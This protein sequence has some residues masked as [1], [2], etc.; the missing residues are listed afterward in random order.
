MTTEQYIYNIATGD[1]I[2]PVLASLIVD[3]SKHETGNYSSRFFT[4]GNNAFGYSYNPESKWQL[5]KGGPNADN[6]V[7]IAQYA[8]LKNSVHEM[9]DWIK[10]RQSD[11]KF[12]GD[13]ASITTPDEYAHLLKSAG[14]YQDAESNYARALANYFYSAAQNFTMTVKK[15]PAIFI[16]GALLIT[17]AVILYVKHKKA[18]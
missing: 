13:L 3:Q 14:Y 16:V 8:N 4:V 12:P 18:V 15:N 2:P 1:G 5:D 17:G 7:P 6:G 11:G 10:R 9:T